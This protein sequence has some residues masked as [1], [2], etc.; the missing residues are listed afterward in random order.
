MGYNTYQIILDNLEHLAIGCCC[1]AI[2]QPVES[3]GILAEVGEQDKYS[4]A[5]RLCSNPG[6]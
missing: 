2:E 3:S 1:F 6:T 5:E 4:K